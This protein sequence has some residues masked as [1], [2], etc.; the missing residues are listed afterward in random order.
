MTILFDLDP[1]SYG[2][3]LQQFNDVETAR[4]QLGEEFLLHQ[5]K[6]D[7]RARLAAPLLGGGTE[8]LCERNSRGIGGAVATREEL[9]VNDVA[10]AQCRPT[11]H[12]PRRH[13]DDAGV[14]RVDASIP[15]FCRRGAGEC[16]K[17]LGAARAV[18][19]RQYV[20]WRCAMRDARR[21]R[22]HTRGA[23][24]GWLG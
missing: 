10:I 4:R 9:A 15:P 6:D 19:E 21:E 14:T 20:S 23:S 11:Q 2:V 17:D 24:V 18:G 12:A 3:G 7:P 22:L 16:G 1:E 8:H 13:V 5:V